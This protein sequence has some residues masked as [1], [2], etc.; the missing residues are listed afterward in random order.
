MCNLEI[1]GACLCTDCFI[2]SQNI[3]CLL[4][5]N[6]ETNV[7][8]GCLLLSVSAGPQSELNL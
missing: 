4:C 5:L 7:H 6:T 1:I 8:L 2:F 3:I